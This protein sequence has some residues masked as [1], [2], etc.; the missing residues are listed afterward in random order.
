MSCQ[1]LMVSRYLL[2]MKL[3]EQ[4]QP[5]IKWLT[6]HSAKYNTLKSIGSKRI[7]SMF[8]LV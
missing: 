6:R 1:D 2:M 4:K 8:V 7:S 5:I 3:G